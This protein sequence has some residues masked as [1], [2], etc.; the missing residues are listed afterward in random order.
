MIQSALTGIPYFMMSFYGLPA[1]VEKRMDFFR[2]RLLWQEDDQKRKYHLV[3]W[4]EVCRPKDMGGLGIQNLACMNKAL[5]CKWWWKLYKTEGLW[6]DIVLEKYVKNRSMGN[7]QAKQGDSQ[8]WR[9][10]LKH[11]DHFVSLCKF[12]IGDGDRTRFWEDWW[13]GNAPLS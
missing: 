8:F 6:Q 1:G 10:I 7:V 11:R 2:A 13:I 4:S 9:D 3:K 12:K 5:L